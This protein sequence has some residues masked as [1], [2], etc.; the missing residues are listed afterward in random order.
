M[1]K[2]T[3]FIFATVKTFN[4]EVVQNKIMSNIVIENCFLEA[5]VIKIS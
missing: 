3:K 5:I 2:K 1:A 4:L